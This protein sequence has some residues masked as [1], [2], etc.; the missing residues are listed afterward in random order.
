MVLFFGYVA[1]FVHR[2]RDREAPGLDHPPLVHFGGPW[3][4]FSKRFWQGRD[5]ALKRGSHRAFVLGV[6]PFGVLHFLFDLVS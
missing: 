3:T 2:Y 4:L 6:L 5:I 1:W